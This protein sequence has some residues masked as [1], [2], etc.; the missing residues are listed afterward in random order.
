MKIGNVEIDQDL[1]FQQRMWRAERIGWAVMAILLLCA[2]LGMFGH[3]ALSRTMALKGD[4]LTVEYQRFGR[5]QAPMEMR[6]YLS[7]GSSQDHPLFF[8]LDRVFL[9]NVQITS[10]FPKPVTE[11]P[12]YDGVQFLFSP[13]RVKGEGSLVVTISYQPKQ[14]GL[15]KA[16]VRGEETTSL[17]VTQFIYP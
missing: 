15:L 11:Q 5:Y 1:E 6:V 17:S 7:A 9:M 12:I 13:T 2:A 16:A 10:I 3:G 14:M 4:L 8:Q